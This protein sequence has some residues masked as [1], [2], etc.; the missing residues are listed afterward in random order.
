MGTTG[1]GG[2]GGTI[3]D[4]AHQLPARELL[5]QEEAA[6]GSSSLLASPSL[7]AAS[8]RSQGSSWPSNP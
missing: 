1:V 7:E 3:S 2:P 5:L 6:S 8:G 4:L